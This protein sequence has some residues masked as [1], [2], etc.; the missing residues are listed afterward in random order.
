[1]VVSGASGFADGWFR[2]GVAEIL[3]GRAAGFVSSLRDDRGVN[4]AGDRVI[5]LWQSP[6][7]VPVAGDMVR[8]TAGCDKTAATCRNRFANFL[9]FRGFPDIPGEDWLMAVPRRSGRNDGSS[10]K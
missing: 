4:L 10:R 3:T 2:S 1:M 5:E 9:N 7:V 8:L 6:V